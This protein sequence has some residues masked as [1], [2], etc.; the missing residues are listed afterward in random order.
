MLHW[1]PEKR[2]SAKS[3]LDH[4]WLKMPKIYN[5]KMN[6]EEFHKY[7]E[8]QS[9]IRESIEDPMTGEEMSKLEETE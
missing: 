1:D 2:A 3:M 5:A 4:P 7:H 8:R 6:D 9:I